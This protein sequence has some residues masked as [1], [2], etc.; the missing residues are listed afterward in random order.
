MIVGLPPR[1]VEIHVNFDREKVEYW[2]RVTCDG[3]SLP[4]SLLVFHLVCRL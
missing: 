3:L 2:F 1:G 4:F